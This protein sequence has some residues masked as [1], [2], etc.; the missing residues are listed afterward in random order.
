MAFPA[1]TAASVT[2]DL[3][4]NIGQTPARRS[5]VSSTE[6]S[7]L[8]G[9]DESLSPEIFCLVITGAPPGPKGPIGHPDHTHFIGQTPDMPARRTKRACTQHPGRRRLDP[10]RVQRSLP[11]RPLRTKIP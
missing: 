4:Q 6:L 3:T 8:T 1:P 2:P 10:L 9:P 7:G 11:L 5:R